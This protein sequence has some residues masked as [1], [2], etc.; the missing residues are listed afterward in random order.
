M[1]QCILIIIPRAAV[2]VLT[3]LSFNVS[4]WCGHHMGGTITTCTFIIILA[5]TR[6]GMDCST[7]GIKGG[8]AAPHV[9][10]HQGHAHYAVRV[11]AR[12]R[13]GARSDRVIDHGVSSER[14]YAWRKLRWLEQTLACC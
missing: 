3:L 12:V 2:F 10:V 9:L 13:E 14:V 5:R 4:S 11:H 7:C 8:A 1:I 6:S